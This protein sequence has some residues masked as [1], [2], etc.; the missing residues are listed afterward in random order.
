MMIEEVI[1]KFKAAL[2]ASECDA[3]LVFGPDNAHY[4]S[5]THLPFTYSYPDRPLALLWPKGREPVCI[6]PVEWESSFRRLSWIGETVGYVEMPADHSKVVSSIVELA[7]SMGVSSGKI[8]I[9]LNRVPI[10]LYEE[11]EEALPKA[12]LVSCDGWLRELRAVKTGK[13]VELLEDLAYRC[14]HAIFGVAH[15]VLVTSTRS[16]MSLSEEI[17]VHAMERELDVIGHHSVGPSASGEHAR[18]Y[19]PLA[20]NYGIGF[21]KHL[22]PGEYV[23]MEL[24]TSLD[25]YWSEGARMIA[26][27]RP[28][29]EQLEA[30]GALVELRKAA[31]AAIKPGARCSSVNTVVNEMAAK[32]GVEL[33]PGLGVGH[34]VGVTSYEPPYLTASEE[35]EI[36]SGMVVVLSPTI[37]GPEGEIMMSKDTLIV[38]DDGCRLVGW[39]MDWREPYV[40]NYTL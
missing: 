7:N 4:L 28:T 8:G 26:M 15:H 18:K 3:V 14:D 20:P 35:A 31:M 6:C 24:R 5:G 36:R 23:R 33:M 13:E 34:G 10:T 25:G 11:L 38:E 30:Y 22:K 12:K 39:Y 1:E 9:D 29:E 2:N 32:K 17:R 37:L 19:W 40:A 27:G 16:E 21:D